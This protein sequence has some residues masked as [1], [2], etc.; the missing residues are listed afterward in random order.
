[1]DNN[2]REMA[3][4]R[5]CLLYGESEQRDKIEEDIRHLQRSD[6]CVRRAVWL[7]VFLTAL[8]ISG[9]GYSAV[10]WVD[11]PQNISRF[12]TQV[13][14]RAFCILGLGS[15][16]CLAAFVALSAVYR[17]RL[18]HRREECRRLAAKLL[19]TRL[20]DPHLAPLPAVIK[21]SRTVPPMAP[22]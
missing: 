12:M 1:M 17:K 11:Y 14:S 10:F 20:G 6:R 13:V 22:G 21:D 3:F 5:H 15:F 16:I 7:M 8:A 2:Q 18:D 4:L 19:E 9:L